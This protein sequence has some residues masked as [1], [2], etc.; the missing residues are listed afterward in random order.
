MQVV[1]FLTSVVPYRFTIVVSG[2]ISCTLFHNNMD[3]FSPLNISIL[4]GLCPHERFFSR[5]GSIISINDGTKFI[6]DIPYA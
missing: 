6:L 1:N 5:E 2:R 4:S 3:R